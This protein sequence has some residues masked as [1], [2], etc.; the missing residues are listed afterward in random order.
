RLRRADRAGVVGDRAVERLVE[1][2]AVIL[3][4]VVLRALL[5]RQVD[6]GVAEHALGHAERV[7]IAV[8]RIDLVVIQTAG[9]REERARRG[10]RPDARGVLVEA[11]ADQR[12]RDAEARIGELVL[13]AD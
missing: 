5:E 1:R 6:A 3:E 13:V 7:L 11:E 9:S 8:A 2:A 4:Q 10:E 12:L